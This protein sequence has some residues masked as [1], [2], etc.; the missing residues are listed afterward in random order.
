[1]PAK[2]MNTMN[3]QMRILNLEMKSEMKK[4]LNSIL[5]LGE[6]RVNKLEERLIEMIKSVEQREKNRKNKKNF[7]DQ[8]GNIKGS[9]IC[10]I[11]TSEG[12]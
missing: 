6:K 11:G 9:N 1:M 5:E 12:E 3:N 8:Y 4:L 2:E 7:S 10:G